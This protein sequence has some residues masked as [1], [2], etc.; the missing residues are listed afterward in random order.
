MGILA[1]NRIVEEGEIL[2]D[3]RDILRLSEDELTKIRG[4]RIAM[5]VPPKGDAFAARNKYALK[6]DYEAQPPFFQVS[7]THYAATWLLDPRSPK[8]DPPT[9]VTE[10]IKR[11]QAL[12]ERMKQQKEKQAKAEAAYLSSASAKSEPTAAPSPVTHK[13]SKKKGGKAS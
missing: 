7:P 5:I 1:P 3:G 2:Y 13:S 12:N 6:V 11:F 8:V 9:S 10:R 4:S